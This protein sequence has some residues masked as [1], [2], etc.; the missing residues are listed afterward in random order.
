MHSLGGCRAP[1]SQRTSVRGCYT[2]TA[3]ARRPSHALSP[4]HSIVSCPVPARHK[5]QAPETPL[6][7]G[8]HLQQHIPRLLGAAAAVTLLLTGAMHAY[9]CGAAHP[10]PFMLLRPHGPPAVANNRLVSPVAHFHIDASS[11]SCMHAVTPF[12]GYVSILTPVLAPCNAQAPATLPRKPS[13]MGDT[14]LKTIQ[15]FATSRIMCCDAPATSSWPRCWNR[16][17]T[18]S[19]PLRRPGS[20]RRWPRARSHP[21]RGRWKV[22]R[23]HHC[24]FACGSHQHTCHQPVLTQAQNTHTAAA[25]QEVGGWGR[26]KLLREYSTAPSFVDVLLN[27]RLSARTI[28]SMS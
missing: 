16:G 20:C 23:I 11:Y 17:G 9:V 1:A 26:P 15:L 5:A 2:A 12:A 21:A 4:T 8:S 10:R 24:V 14:T 7:S 22:R 13:M 28:G 6:D 27:C 3:A 25:T 19:C 18:C